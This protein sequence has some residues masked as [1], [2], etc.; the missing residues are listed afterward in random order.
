MMAGAKTLSTKGRNIHRI[1]PALFCASLVF[2]IGIGSALAT[3][4]IRMLLI[5]K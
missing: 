4:E 2:S 1:I 3:P 5:P